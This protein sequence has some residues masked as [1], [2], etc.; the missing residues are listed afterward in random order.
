V[1]RK[2]GGNE[3]GRGLLLGQWKT[4]LIVRERQRRTLWRLLLRSARDWREEEGIVEKRKG[5]CQR[6]RER[7][8]RRGGGELTIVPGSTSLTTGRERRDASRDRRRRSC[9]S[10]K[11]SSRSVWVMVSRESD[12]KRERRGGRR[13]AR[14]VEFRTRRPRPREGNERKEGDESREGTI[15]SPLAILT[16]LK[17]ISV[18]PASAPIMFLVPVPLS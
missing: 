12:G 18:N 16:S 11:A 7:R 3:L 13:S 10:A 14:R 1:K 9:S 6:E 17:L 2:R 4:K 15:D 5:G 8:G